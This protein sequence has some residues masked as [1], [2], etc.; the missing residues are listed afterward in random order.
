MSGSRK[1]DHLVLAVADLRSARDRLTS[2]GFLAAPDARHPFGTENAC[3][4]FAD[5]TYLEPLAI[6]SQTESEESARGGNVFT[7]RDRAFRFRHGPEGL[8]AVVLASADA[9]ADHQAFVQAGISAGGMLSFSRPFILPDGSASVASF[10]LAFAADLRSPDFYAFAC[11]RVNPPNVD[12]SALT[13]HPN[14]VVGMTGVVLVETRPEDFAGFLQD[15]SG[16]MTVARSGLSLDIL[17][18]NARLHVL[19][20]DDYETRFGQKHCAHARGL[21]GKAICFSAASLE[22]LEALFRRNG[23][24]HER[25]GERLVVPPM[26]GQGVLY[27]FEERA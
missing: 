5:D 12:R 22:R 24:V 27:S 21:R 18:P 11:E 6:G 17:M 9:R 26:P 20:P 3:V 19:T 16:S 1:V 15:V 25:I 23:V 7:A 8:E 10:E 14:G 13:A 2:L 4:F